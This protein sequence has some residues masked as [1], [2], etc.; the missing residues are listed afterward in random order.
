LGQY[1]FPANALVS[2][3]VVRLVLDKLC[4]FGFASLEKLIYVVFFLGI[5]AFPSG[6]LFEYGTLAILLAMFGYCVRNND[7][8]SLSRL[9]K[10]IFSIFV[11]TFATVLQI[12]MFNFALYQSIACVLGMGLF[13]A[14]LFFFKPVEY[15]NLTQKMPNLFKDMIAFGGRYTLEIYII[16]LVLFKAMA[17]Y[18]H[19][20]HYD[21]FSPTYFPNFPA[22]T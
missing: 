12:I 10:T 15:P 13:G 7:K 8:I 22:P 17:L 6:F 18:L 9:T 1:S 5:L 3:I 2:I 21:W 4:S 14:I 20:G 11:I 19:Y 16:H